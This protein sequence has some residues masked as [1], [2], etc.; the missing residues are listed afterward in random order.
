M[1][2]H[3]LSFQELR[4][5]FQAGG[6]A[7]AASERLYSTGLAAIDR[8]LGGGLPCGSLVTLEGGGSAGCRSIAAALLAMAT[9]RGLGAIIDGGDLYPPG[10]EA[11]GVRLDRLLVVP[12][13]TPVGIARAVDLLLR[14]RTA[15][16]VVM[17]ATTLRSAV[18][19]RLASLAHKAGAILVVMA[20]RAAAELCGAA[21]VRV[22]CRIGGAQAAGTSGLWGVFTGFDVRAELRKHKPAASGVS[23]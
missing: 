5:R 3:S 9:Q 23:A 7:P 20:A 10:L 19:M 4:A 12:A 13:K 1:L 17:T 14:S 21:R 11:A 22:Q 6:T 16:V 15:R 2:P 18:W 8:M